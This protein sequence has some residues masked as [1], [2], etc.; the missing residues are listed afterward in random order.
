MKNGSFGLVLALV[1]YPSNGMWMSLHDDCPDIWQVHV[2]ELKLGRPVRVMT[3]MDIAPLGDNRCHVS[4]ISQISPIEFHEGAT[5]PDEPYIY[6]QHELAL[7]KEAGGYLAAATE[8]DGCWF[9]MKACSS[10]SEATAWIKAKIAEK[11]RSK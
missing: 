4:W 9:D 6:S 10:S 2:I 8:Y 11:T 7:G 1:V 5:L 3:H